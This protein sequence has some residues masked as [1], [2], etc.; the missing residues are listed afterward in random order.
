MPKPIVACTKYIDKCVRLDNGA[1]LVLTRH[2][3]EFLDFA[4]SLQDGHAR[5][6]TIVHS[7]PKKSGKTELAADV[8]SWVLNTR[9]PRAEVLVAGNDQEQSIE[10]VFSRLVRIQQGHPALARRIAKATD[11][12]LTLTDGST[13]KALALDAKGEAGANPDCVIHDEAWGIISEEARR[14]FD[15]L[16][17]PPTKPW[18]FRWVS[19]Y[20]GYP[21]ESKT[22]ESLYER[23]TKGRRVAAVPDVTTNGPLCML[24][25]HVSRMPWQTGEAGRRYYA[26]Q[27]EDLRAN[28]FLRL[29]ENRWVSGESAFI[30]PEAWDA[31]GDLALFPPSPNVQLEL[32]GGLDAGIK[33]DTFAVVTLYRD[34]R[35]QLCLGPFRIWTPR[36]L[37]PVDFGDVEAWLLNLHAG[38]RLRRL[39]ADPYQMASSIERLRQCGVALE[40]FPQT[41]PNL[42]RAT[43][44][45]FDVVQD[46]RL[47]VYRIG[48]EALRE[49]VLN[50]V[51]V[52]S[53]RGLRLEKVSGRRKIDAAVALSLAVVAALETPL[54]G[55][56]GTVVLAG[57]PTAASLDPQYGTARL[58]L[59]PETP[60]RTS[61]DDRSAEIQ[62]EWQSRGGADSN[63]RGLII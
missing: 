13:C 34:A 6:Q 22:L 39:L 56:V 63:R 62:A 11:T 3:R 26:A 54:H 52:E 18:A 24:W 41:L 45:L 23:G 9:G 32:V 57:R 40:E 49:Q 59:R 44:A 29:H 42:T 21:G 36:F 27:K 60:V 1:A 28:A 2:Q 58:H 15:E 20:A 8:A 43:Q 37:R 10:R 33:H 53:A 19:S 7:E 5:F 17:P 30:T 61:S 51:A 31:C 38:F 16:T 25:S 46:R 35:G 4:L 14:L 55:G 47:R 12:L 48:A 50:A